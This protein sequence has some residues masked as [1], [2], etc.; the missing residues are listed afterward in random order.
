MASSANDKPDD[1]QPRGAIDR[2]KGQ[3]SQFF[4]QLGQNLLRERDTEAEKFFIAIHNNDLAAVEKILDAGFPPNTYHNS[5]DTGLHW[6]ARKGRPA[7]AQ[8]LLTRGANPATGLRD[9]PADTPL[10]DAIN[11]GHQDVGVVLVKAGALMT[12]S[13]EMAEEAL[14]RATEKGLCDLV[15]ALIA[16]GIDPLEPDSTGRT[17]VSTAMTARQGDL[18]LRLL[19]DQQIAGSINQHFTHRV[20]TPFHMAIERG[21][22]SVAEKML[23]LGAYSNMV[24]RGGVT[25]LHLAI[26][27]G[28]AQLVSL[29]IAH[30]A[31]VNAPSGDKQSSPLCVLARQRGFDGDNRAIIARLLIAAGADIN[32]ANPQSGDTPLLALMEAQNIADTM[33]LFIEAGADIHA[34]DS[35]GE[36]VLMRAIRKA[37][38]HE[39]VNLIDAGV[40]VNQRHGMDG[41]TALMLA[42]EGGDLEEAQELIKAGANARLLDVEGRSALMLARQSPKNADKMV[43]LLEDALKRDTKP[44]FRGVS[45]P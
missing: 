31:D 41:K 24:N 29:L 5:G 38:V 42:V 19:D 36:T 40:N 13:L 27:R 2:A 23:T 33:R 9:R 32:R 7:I 28:D 39:V 18:L 11:F 30:G 26:E 1:K 12:A 8:L 10:R 20:Q 22:R 43:P 35:T 4:S 6:C 34:T 25:P 21:E 44:R 45:G 15:E 17:V 14:H 37:T 16:Q 3:F